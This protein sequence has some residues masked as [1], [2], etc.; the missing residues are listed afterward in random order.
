MQ[1]DPME[2]NGREHQKGVPFLHGEKIYLRTLLYSDCDGPYLT[3]FNDRDVC[4]G[5]SHHIFPYTLDQARTYAL[6]SSQNHRSALILAI[7]EKTSDRHIG[8]V[9]LDTI[10]YISRC[11]EFSIIIGEKKAWGRGY[12]REAGRLI[13]THGFCTLNLHRI[14]CG[15]LETNIAM[16]RLARYLKME[17]E[18]C[19][20]QAIFKNGRYLDV[21]EFGVLAKEFDVLQDHGA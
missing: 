7:I 13:I 6:Q 9:A 4:H 2:Q 10:D 17:Q 1:N 15:T 12:G 21:I 20:R 3:W 11:A 14:S 8:N 5:N 19:R 16:I 18:G